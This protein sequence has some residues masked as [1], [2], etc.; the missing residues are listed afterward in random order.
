MAQ[1]VQPAD[2]T[3]A[4]QASDEQSSAANASHYST[5]EPDSGETTAGFGN[6]AGGDARSESLSARG[7]DVSDSSFDLRASRLAE[8]P[9]DSR[10]VE[11][12]SPKE[13]AAGVPAI[14]ATM[15]FSLREMGVGRS[16]KTLLRVNQ[17]D[18]FDCPGCAWP[19]PDGERHVAEF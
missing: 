10:D 4:P 6:D 19:E 18:G 15:K 5:T 7:R 13:V 3:N 17:K 16:L 11:I 1:T 2:Q 8:S 12:E 14:Y 9:S